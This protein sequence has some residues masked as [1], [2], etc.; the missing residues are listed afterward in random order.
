MIEASSMVGR[1]N[2]VLENKEVILTI[3]TNGAMTKK[4]V[5]NEDWSSEFIENKGP[6]KVVL[7][8]C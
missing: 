1:K 3:F 7:R 4:D 6:K 8:V 2:E 5:K